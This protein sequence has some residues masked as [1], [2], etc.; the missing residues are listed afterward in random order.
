MASRKNFFE[1]KKVLITGGAG[2]I[3]S[4]IL[5]SI[6]KFRPK[7]VR[8]LD[9]NENRQF[10]LKH[11]LGSPMNVGFLIGDIRDRERMMMAVEDID[12]IFHAAAL[13][14]VPLCEYN[15]FEAAKTNV[16]GT[17]NVIEAALHAEVE[18]MITI[19]TDKAVNP[20]NVMG[21]TKLLA[22]RLT[23]NANSYKGKKRTVFSCVRFGN[24]LDSNGSVIPLMKKQ[25]KA[26]GPVTITDTDMTRFVMSISKA[27]D[28]VLKAT[29]E[30]KAGDIYILK[31]PV[32]RIE[33]LAEVMIEELAP[34]YGFK[35]E[36]IKRK[37][38]GRRCGEK[39]FEEL[40]TQDE[41]GNM[42][43]EELM[44]KIHSLPDLVGTIQEK[45]T[46]SQYGKTCNIDS[47]N[48]K[49]L[50][51]EELRLLLKEAGII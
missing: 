49:A 24:V 25:I 20:V 18:K 1:G 36:Q 27:V 41:C 14:H 16:F 19:S 4:E 28:L 23:I 21:A 2:S 44:F 46:E 45:K 39:L 38:I 31:M 50:S 6:L 32:M 15:P 12:I 10:E 3:G 26:G 48:A 9:I 8:S 34:A 13:K 51:R 35:P 17:Q 43:E 37:I 42:E 30:A 40:M 5:R 33:D 22:E 7:S 11:E 47:K 29:T